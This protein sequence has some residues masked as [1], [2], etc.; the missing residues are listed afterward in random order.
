MGGEGASEKAAVR[1]LELSRIVLKW[2]LKTKFKMREPCGKSSEL[3]LDLELCAGTDTHTIT[4]TVTHT[5]ADTTHCL[6]LIGFDR[7]NIRLSPERG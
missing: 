6:P 7:R 4:D 5:F 1:I 3:E 2:K